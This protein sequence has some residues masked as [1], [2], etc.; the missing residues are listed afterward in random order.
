MKR[1]TKT[2]IGKKG[3]IEAF[4]NQKKKKSILSGGPKKWE[5]VR[6]SVSLIVMTAFLEIGVLLLLISLVGGSFKASGKSFVEF[7]NPIVNSASV[8][9]VN[10]ANPGFLDDAGLDFRVSIPATWIGW[11]Y[12]IGNVKSPIDDSLSDQYVQVFLPDESKRKSNNFDERQR[13]MFTI[14][15]YSEKEWKKISTSCEKENLPYCDMMGKEIG[16][17]DG[18]VFSYFSEKNCPK[19]FEAKCREVDKI[20]ESFKLK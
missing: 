7:P 3:T 4:F 9:N 10:P 8:S 20:L 16:R 11:V 13:K 12:K 5:H 14:M 6:F 18:S 19:V 17:K 1:R 2:K 15:K